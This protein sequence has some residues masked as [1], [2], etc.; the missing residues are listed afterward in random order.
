MAEGVQDVQIGRSMEVVAQEHNTLQKQHEI[1]KELLDPPPT[2]ARQHAVLQ[3]GL[4][5]PPGPPPPAT[6]GTAK[7]FDDANN[8][9]SGRNDD[10]D[11]TWNAIMQKHRVTAPASSSTSPP[12]PRPRAHEPSIGAAEL[13]E[14]SEDFIKKIHHAFGRHP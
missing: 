13:S 7:Y 3:P 6:M 9:G 14:R 1:E 4:S 11:V 10:L 2:P 5:L 12:V 8:D